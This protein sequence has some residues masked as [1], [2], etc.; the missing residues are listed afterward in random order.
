MEIA[1]ILKFV[2]RMAEVLENVLRVAAEFNV[3]Q[4]QFVS[5]TTI[6][7][8]VF[9]LKATKE[10]PLILAKVAIRKKNYLNQ[11]DATLLLADEV[12]FAR[13]IIKDQSAIVKMV[14]FGI[15]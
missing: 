13:L 6:V 2:S 1:K 14:S 9:A 10:I 3:D 8:L 11:K 12:K 4:I 7:Q 5:L 15:Q